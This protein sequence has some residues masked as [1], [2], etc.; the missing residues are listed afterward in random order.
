MIFQKA[1]SSFGFIQPHKSL[2]NNA[3]CFSMDAFK[4]SAFPH[5]SSKA[6]DGPV[7]C[8][9]YI[10]TSVQM[11]LSGILPIRTF[12]CKPEEFPRIV[13]KCTQRTLRIS[14]LAAA[15]LWQSDIF[16]SSNT[17]KTRSDSNPTVR[18]PVCIFGRYGV[19]KNPPFGLFACKEGCINIL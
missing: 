13:S 11:F 7:I 2:E 1:K 9:F 17:W 10:S 15:I 14:E 12:L 4:M 3:A 5:H 16:V 18:G 8:S 19:I 6:P